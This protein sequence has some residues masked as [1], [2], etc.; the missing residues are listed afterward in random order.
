MG[1]QEL[2]RDISRRQ[3]SLRNPL[4]PHSPNW[5]EICTLRG[6][7]QADPHR[8]QVFGL[9]VLFG[10]SCTFAQEGRETEEV[11]QDESGSERLQVSSPR[12]WKLEEVGPSLLLGEEKLRFVSIM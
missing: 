7:H 10:F 4:N 6:S 5:G 11:H 8:E 9:L 3:S 1:A 12:W 2:T